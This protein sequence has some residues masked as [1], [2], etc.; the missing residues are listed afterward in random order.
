M[1]ISITKDWPPGCYLLKLV[2]N[3]GQEQFVPLTVRDDS[4]HGRRTSCRTA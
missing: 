3:G 2:G 1:T 4:L